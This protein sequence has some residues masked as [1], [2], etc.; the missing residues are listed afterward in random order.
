MKVIALESSLSDLH[1]QIDEIF[2]LIILGKQEIINSQIIDHGTFINNYVQVLGSKTVGNAFI[3]KEED[4][5]NILDIS[6]LTLL[7]RQKKVFF[8]ISVPTIIDMEWDIEQI[9]H[10]P[11]LT[12]K[13]FLA[14]LVVHPIFLTSGLNYINADQNYLDK[15]C[16]S[17]SDF[18]ICKQIQPIHD[19]REKH[20]CNSEIL[21]V[22]NTVKFY[23]VVVY[24]IE[25]I[26]SIPLNAANHFIAIPKKPIHLSIFEEKTHRIVRLEE[27]SLLQTN[28][29]VNIL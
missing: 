20:Y 14:P 9:Y 6:E 10:I 18:Y 19:R 29:T 7:T 26:S 28:T 27:P 24:N 13:V 23:K 8:L 2:N 5:Q 12:N 15:Q 17:I 1:F 22:E 16:R 4:F 21:S 11:S 3:P 25:V